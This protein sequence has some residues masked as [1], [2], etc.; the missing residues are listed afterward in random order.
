[1]ISEIFNKYYHKNVKIEVIGGIYIEGRIIDY[2]LEPDEDEEEEGIL[3]EVEKSNK[4]PKGEYVLL[5]EEEIISVTT[6]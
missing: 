5:H 3:V 2:Y 6:L 1:M 4:I